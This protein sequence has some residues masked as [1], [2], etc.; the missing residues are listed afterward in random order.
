MSLNVNNMKGGSINYGEPK[1]GTHYGRLVGFTYLGIQERGDYK[2]QPKD[3]CPQVVLTFELLDDHIHVEDGT[4]LPRIV[5]KRENAVNDPKANVVKYYHALDPTGQFAG[6]YEALTKSQPLCIITIGPKRDTQGKALEGWRIE[7]I[8]GAPGGIEAPA[9]MTPAV[10]FDFDAPTLESYAALYNWQR[11]VIGEAKNFEGSAVQQIAQQY[12]AQQ[13]AQ[14]NQAAGVTQG[15]VMQ[16]A[17]PPPMAD[18]AGPQA[19]PAAAPA[20]PAQGPNIQVPPPTASQAAA[21]AA[22]PTP[23]QAATPAASSGQAQVPSAPPGF[24]YDPATNSY[25]PEQQALADNNQT[26]APY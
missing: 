17:T 8:S 6:D 1:H 22:P 26:A 25:V 14:Q 21:Q 20:A 12:E 16:P 15:Q 3:P 2:G 4:V 9:A 18:Q 19:V 24:R 5:S 13:Q 11:K 10:V 7:Q 23:P